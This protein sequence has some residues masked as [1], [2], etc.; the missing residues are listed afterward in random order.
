MTF[1]LNHHQLHS[2][3]QDRQCQDLIKMSWV[4]LDAV[5]KSL[6]ASPCF[7]HPQQVV[8]VS[9]F[10][11]Y[12]CV[13]FFCR[14]CWIQSTHRHAD[15]KVAMGSNPKC[16]PTL[17]FFAEGV[18]CWCSRLHRCNITNVSLTAAEWELGVLYWKLIFPCFFL[19]TR[20]TC[21]HPLG[22][23]AT[24]NFQEDKNPTWLCPL[25]MSM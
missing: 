13:G 3:I 12:N 14:V 2:L 21:L 4:R 10:P 25:N 1:D 6:C 9:T 24:L 22:V 8:A 18:F 23:R 20:V 19:I 7:S 11:S 17:T 16:Y 5:K 15:L